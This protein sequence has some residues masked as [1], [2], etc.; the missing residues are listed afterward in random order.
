MHALDCKKLI[1]MDKHDLE[2]E[3]M[4]GTHGEFLCYFHELKEPEMISSFVQ[5]CN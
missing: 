5:N 1:L 4:V 2:N 3:I